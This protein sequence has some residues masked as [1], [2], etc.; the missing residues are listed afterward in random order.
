MFDYII[1][2]DGGYLISNNIGAGAYIILKSDNQALVTQ[3]SF[4]TKRHTSQRV[5][6]EAIIAAVSALPYGSRAQVCTDNQYATLILG[7]VPKRKNKPNIDL[8]VHYKQLVR[9]KKL[10][11]EFKWIPSHG[12]HKWNELCDSLCTEAL[13]LAGD[14]QYL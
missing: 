14:P 11:I 5:E 8:L 6:L 9:Q 2:T 1:Y 7:K 3:N 12:G 4:V 10:K 13:S